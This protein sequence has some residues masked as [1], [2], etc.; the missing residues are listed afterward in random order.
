MRCTWP[1]APQ[2]VFFPGGARRPPARAG[3]RRHRGRCGGGDTQESGT[4][5]RVVDVLASGSHATF[6]RRLQSQNPL[7]H[8]GVRRRTPKLYPHVLE[9]TP[10]LL[11]GCNRSDG[12][13][14]LVRSRP[15][16]GV[17]GGPRGWTEELTC[18]T[19]SW[20]MTPIR[21][22]PNY[23]GTPFVREE[24]GLEVA[25]KGEA[26]TRPAAPSEPSRGH[27]S[28]PWQSGS[29]LPPPPCP[30]YRSPRSPRRFDVRAEA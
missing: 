27:R 28:C 26:E 25:G 17:S 22:S 2:T 24:C 29:R 3:P 13:A 11:S 20:C 1:H 10:K 5:P 8:K 6:L 18:I 15:K 7:P 23:P 16:F 4:H 12:S 9:K 21:A 30:P 19:G 14:P